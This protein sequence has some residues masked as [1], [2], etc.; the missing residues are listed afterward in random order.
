M[1]KV[2]CGMETV[3]IWCGTVGEMRNAEICICG[4]SFVHGGIVHSCEWACCTLVVSFNCMKSEYVFVIDVPQV[5]VFKSRIYRLAFYVGLGLEH[6][7]VRDRRRRSVLYR[8]TERCNIKAYCSRATY[9]L[10]VKCKQ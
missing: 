3:E 6:R 1:R 8:L 5:V 9:M 7:P 2:K 10:N 4:C